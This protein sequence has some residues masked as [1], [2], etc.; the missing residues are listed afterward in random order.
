MNRKILTNIQNTLQA[1]SDYIENNV[2]QVISPIFHVSPLFSIKEDLHSPSVAA[3]AAYLSAIHKHPEPELCFIFLMHLTLLRDLS[4]QARAQVDYFQSLCPTL[5]RIVHNE[6]LPCVY[7]L[8]R[9]SNDTPDVDPMDGRLFGRLNWEFTNAAYGVELNDPVIQTTLRL[10]LQ[11][12]AELDLRLDL[13]GLRLSYPRISTPVSMI[14][15][16]GQRFR[17]TEFVAR[18]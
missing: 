9:T 18:D 8:T 3:I 7:Y 10:W 6:F 12:T 17:K 11:I 1:L 15:V 16:E 5:N 4:L 14:N 2:A 13:E